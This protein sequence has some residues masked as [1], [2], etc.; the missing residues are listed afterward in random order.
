MNFR[1]AYNLIWI[2]KGK[3]W[4]IAFWI[5]YK[6]FKY[7]IILFRL[8]NTLVTCQELL[9]WILRKILDN[10]VIIYLNNIFIYSKN[11]KK[12]VKYIQ[13]IFQ[14]LKEHDLQIKLKKYFFHKNEIKFLK[15]QIKIWGI[16]MEL[17]KIQ[18]IFNWFISKTLKEIQK[19]L[20]FTNYNWQFIKKYSKIIH[21]LTALIKKN[22]LFKWDQKQEE[23]FKQLK[24]ACNKHPVL[25][26]YNSTK[27]IQ[28]KTN[29]NDLMIKA[30][31]TQE[32][33]NKKHL[34]AYYSKKNVKNGTKL[35][36]S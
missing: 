10:F 3:E 28:L 23:T 31:F 33:D 25:W 12:H 19:F 5:R 18:K 35:Q 4:K 14:W 9:N 29:A 34:I 30:C 2:K 21:F 24:Q 20:R 26:I 27:L 36:H 13:Y 8:I 6:H 16:K 17:I 15:Y 22:V 1:G 11:K 32:Y 7:Q